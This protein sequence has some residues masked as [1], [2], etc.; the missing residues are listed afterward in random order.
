MTREDVGQLLGR[1]GSL[2]QACDLDLLLFFSR[3]SHSFLASESLARLLG[4]DLNKIAESL[5]I[6][7]NMGLITRAQTPA[8]AARLYVLA[9]DGPHVEWLPSLVQ[10]ASTRGGRLLLL[11]ALR[12]A[13]Q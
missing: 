13:R 4:Y 5:E 12:H 2:R 6:L 1:V 3:H 10:A 7:L 9:M 11:Q 8:H